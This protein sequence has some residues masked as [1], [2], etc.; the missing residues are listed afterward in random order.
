[1]ALSIQIILPSSTVSYTEGVNNVSK[2]NV[3]YYFANVVQIVIVMVSGS[4]IVYY[5]LP[6]ILSIP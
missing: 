6:C 2:I 1:M 3:K 5:Q 4:Q